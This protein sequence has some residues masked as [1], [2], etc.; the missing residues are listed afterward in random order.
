MESV[1]SLWRSHEQIGMSPTT[2][3]LWPLQ[4]VASAPKQNTLAVSKA[5]HADGSLVGDRVELV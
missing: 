1:L 3:D 2:C 4:H 5:E